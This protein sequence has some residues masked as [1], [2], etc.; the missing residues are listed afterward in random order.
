MDKPKITAKDFF[1]WA[2]VVVTL[3]WS[4][5][6]YTLLVFDYI[7]YTYPN[8]LAYYPSDPYQSGISG[9]MA[10]IIVLF[11]L[12]VLLRVV[13][14][15]TVIS[16]PSRNE[17][18]VRRWA[19]LLTLFL[20]GVAIAADLITLL[21]SFLSG[22]E[23][24]ANFLLKVFVILL[25]AAGI[26]MHF[27]S[28]LWG[29]WEQYPARKRYVSVGVGIL[30]LVT[31]I[32]GFF[33]VGTPGEARKARFDDQKVADL[34]TI[35]SSVTQY[36]Q[37]K[38]VLPTTLNDLDTSYVNEGYGRTPT[39]PQTGTSYS[40]RPTGATSFELCATFN[41]PTRTIPETMGDRSAPYGD[42]QDWSHGAGQVCFTRTIDPAFYP[43][44]IGAQKVVPM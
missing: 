1:L 12:F 24:T 2:G 32:A 29:Y 16:D 11:P 9:E 31:I 34:R 20:A 13:I 5:I 41:Q 7:N 38:R 37:N 22:E 30:A 43:A 35:G 39:D 14:R 33:I 21:T 4:V 18:W 19:L 27:I 40:Y 26:F 10:S 36:W 28:D 15:K 25:V 6:A 44:P 42:N 8:P 3:Y 17:I 23:L